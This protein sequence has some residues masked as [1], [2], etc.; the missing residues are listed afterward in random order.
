MTMR[1]RWWMATALAVAGLGLLVMVIVY[2]R[3]PATR[4]FVEGPP[5]FL[6]AV[7][8]RAPPGGQECCTDILAAG[9][10]DKNGHPD[11]VI[12]SQE[13]QGPGLVWYAS[14]AWVRRPIADGE[15]TTDGQIADVDADGD[16]DVIV[17]AWAEPRLMWFEN[18]GDGSSWTPHLIG[19]G[20]V[21]DIAVADL[22]GNRLQDIVTCDK[23]KVV[24]WM[25]EPPGQ[26]RTVTVVERPGEGIALADLDGDQDLDLVL[27]GVWMENPSEA[28]AAWREHVFAPSWPRDARVRAADMNG[29]GRLDLLLS[30][31]EGPGA[32]SWFAVPSDPN[33]SNWLEH[34]IADGL[35]G[36]HSLAVADLD[37][38][39]DPDVVGAEMHTAPERRVFVLIN[40]ADAWRMLTIDGRGSHNMVVA[41]VDDDGDP[42][43]V[44]KN[45][46]GAGRALEL[47]ENLTADARLV[48]T[49]AT[50]QSAGWRYAAID[51]SRP[52]D[53]QGKMGLAFA[54][55]DH[56]GLLDVVA[57]S[58]VYR[59]GKSKPDDWQ[60]TRLPGQIDVFFAV[61]VD[62]DRFTDLIGFEGSRAIWLET[63]EGAARWQAQDVARIPDAR[64]QGY[65]V[66]DLDGDGRSELVFTR[67]QGLFF[68]QVPVNPQGDWRVTEVTRA[69]EEE[70]IAL[71]DI[72]LDGD[73][74]I[75]AQGVDGHSTFWFENRLA[76]GGSWAA[77]QIGVAGR[78]ID[79][80]VLADAD[81]DGR[82]ELYASEESRDHHYDAHLYQ[83]R[84]ADDPRRPWRRR[85]LLVLR[86]I[87]SLEAADMDGD[88]DPDLVV[89]EHNDFDE[90]VEVE[91]NITGILYNDAAGQNWRFMTIEAGT[92]SSHLGGRTADLDADGDLD[93]VSIAWQQFRLVHAWLNPGP[94]KG[95]Q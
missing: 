43:V 22:D 39:G 93:I 10:L 94:T 47:W 53:Q 34:R 15:F 58:W 63:D 27:S 18:S 64:T 59:Q 24:A 69:C 38:D 35:V 54:D 28:R 56:N 66:G 68:I 6:R 76:A 48:P 70:G 49:I 90:P 84:P 41:D 32:I 80:V 33:G 91:D 46:A 14:P 81:G 20:Y 42:D 44:G 88:G 7:I 86:S 12:G 40:E 74:D 51:D 13:G 21:H 52:E 55:V 83:F 37:L 62:G 4:R 79:R 95:G 57:G 89:A 9:D 78:W 26:W 72:D 92:H 16:L 87:N 61:D 8:D 71:G 31:S 60:G 73:L 23:E 50:S 30:A 45:Y 17:G 77:H 3:T 65:A 75:V 85:A 1:H 29:D 19:D 2:L 25:Q 67:G 11:L 36:V 82:L 5:P